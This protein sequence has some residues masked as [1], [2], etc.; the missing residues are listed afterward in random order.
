[1]AQA[2]HRARSTRQDIFN[3]YVFA[4]GS[5]GVAAT[6][7]NRKVSWAGAPAPS[8]SAALRDGAQTL[9]TQG[10]V[11]QAAADRFRQLGDEF[12]IIAIP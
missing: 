9:A 8:A 1:V 2:R 10:F 11:T 6:R 5:G 12:G 3:A 7:E 4:C